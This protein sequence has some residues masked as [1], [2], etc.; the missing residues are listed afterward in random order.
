MAVKK[1]KKK[2][3]GE[4]SGWREHGKSERWKCNYLL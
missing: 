3:Q 2:I 1:F 4:P